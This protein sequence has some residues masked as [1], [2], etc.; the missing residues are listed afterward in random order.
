MIRRLTLLTLAVVTASALIACSSTSPSTVLQSVAVSGTAPARG[1]SAQFSAIATY[2]DGSTKDVTANTTWSSSDQT[3]A[4]V[5]STGVVTG[6]ADG[7]ATITAT[8]TTMSAT[9]VVQIAG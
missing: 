8:Y 5:S 7:S 1:A 2:A 3:I 9:D 4:T 6:V